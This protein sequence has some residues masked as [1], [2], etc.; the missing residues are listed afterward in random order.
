M[1]VATA[2]AL[3]FCLLMVVVIAVTSIAGLV[4]TGRVQYYILALTGK[5]SVRDFEC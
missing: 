3:G 5:E 2:K 1:L 4:V